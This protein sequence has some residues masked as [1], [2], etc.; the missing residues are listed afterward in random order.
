MGAEV[1]SVSVARVPANADLRERLVHEFLVDVGVFSCMPEPPFN[2]LPT[3]PA[4]GEP[5]IRFMRR[6]ASPHGVDTV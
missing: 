4:M 6:C 2:R 1:S 3:R 5:F